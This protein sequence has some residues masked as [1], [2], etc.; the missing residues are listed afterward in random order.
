[1]TAFGPDNEK[2]AT[3]MVMV[4]VTVSVTATQEPDKYR[5]YK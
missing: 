2:A 1:M 3:V 4:M 5:P